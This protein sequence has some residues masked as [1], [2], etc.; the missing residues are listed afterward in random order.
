MTQADPLPAARPASTLAPLRVM[1]LI[2]AL[3]AEPEGLSLAQLSVRLAV[4]KSSLLSLLR[5]LANGGYV[6]GSGGTYRIGQESFVLGTLITRSRPFPDNLRPLLA[7][8]HRACGHT[9]L[10]AVPGEGGRD[11][12][13]VD[14][15]ESLQSLRFKVA[16]GSRDPIYC[17]ALGLAMLAHGP[18]EAREQYI[19]TVQL[20]P[21]TRDTIRSRDALRR[22]LHDVRSRTL[23]IIP[24][25]I[26]ENVTAIAA[27]IFDASGDPVA[28]VGLAGPSVDVEKSLSTLSDHVRAAGAAMSYRLGCVDY[29]PG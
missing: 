1:Q 24:S 28:A 25:G 23:S 8:L 17:T 10:V 7:D 27:P 9:V 20:V 22:L 11:I 12:V 14:L 5:T 26:N 16:V 21:R 18:A 13:Y 4:P 2:K 29:P 6:E 15:I 19:R 3:A